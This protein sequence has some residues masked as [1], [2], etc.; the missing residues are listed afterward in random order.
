MAIVRFRF[1]EPMPSTAE[2]RSQLRGVLGPR[3]YKAIDGVEA[4]DGAA[5]HTSDGVLLIT[6]QDYV[7]LAYA[8]KLCI[9]SGGI[10]LDYEGKAVQRRPQDW[11]RT[12]WPK[13]SWVARLKIRFGRG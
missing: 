10:S 9:D 11:T 8:R 13:H 12:P 4:G 7:A 5:T 6:S 2:L 1:D 3:L